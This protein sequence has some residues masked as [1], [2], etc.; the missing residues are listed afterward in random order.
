[1]TAA[2]RQIDHIVD[3]IRATLLVGLDH[4]TDAVPARQLRFEAQA[5]KQVEGD[6][7]AV[8]FFGV[9]VEA[10]VVLLGQQGQ[11]QQARVQLVHHAL[12]LG[13]A[14][15]RVQGRQLD[16]DARAFVD[17]TAVGSL[18]DRVD[19]LLVGRQVLLCVMFG[20]CG[21]TEHVVGVTEALGFKARGVGQGFGDGLAGDKLLAH[22]AH[23]HVDALAD[24]R[25]ATFAD[26]AAQGGGQA[27]FVVRRHQF[28][29]Q[30]QAPGGGVDE[31]RRAI[32][33]VRVPVAGAD[34]VADQ[35]VTGA[36][37]RDTQQRFGQA[38]QGY[39]FLGRQGKFLQQA[40][41][42]AGTATGALLIAQFFGNRGGQGLCG[43]GHRGRQ[44]RLLQQHGHHFGFRA[45]VRRGDGRAQH[46]L[47][48]DA[49]GELQEA[50]MRMVGLYVVG[51]I[52]GSARD[53][54]QLGQGCTTLEFFQVIED[55]LLDQ[56]VWRA[57]NRGRGGLEA[58]AGWVIKFDPKGGGSHFF[59]LMGA[60]FAW[61]QLAARLALR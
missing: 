11:R 40:L 55:C 24:H 4:E 58:L 44:A 31:Q 6:F 47:R 18:A 34:L 53:T 32:A 16:G 28:A 20:Q 22:Q 23:G 54:A 15:A 51:V 43:F 59:I 3:H 38:H 33:Q 2:A 49:F 17:A 41:D 10:N 48:Q 56:P 9:N 46:G 5:L 7:Q 61:Q 29:G 50:L 35:G 21:F 14:V 52:A 25:L 19:G 39:A 45:T 27:G 37:V 1:M 36:L 60:T 26:D 12:V 8:G 13:A 42:D 30:Q 57:I